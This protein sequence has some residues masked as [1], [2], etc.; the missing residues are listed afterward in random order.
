MKRQTVKK[1]I[2][3]REAIGKFQKRPRDYVRQRI[4]QRYYSSKAQGPALKAALN[5][6]LKGATVDELLAEDA[7]LN[8]NRASNM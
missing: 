7:V 4:V 5:L 6:C 8:K 1:T 2:Q 3:Y